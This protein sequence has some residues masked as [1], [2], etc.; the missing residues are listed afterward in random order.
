MSDSTRILYWVD[1]GLITFAIARSLQEKL[2]SESFAIYDLN[3]HLKNSFKDQKLVKFKKEWF[4][5]D[6]LSKNIEKVDLEYLKKIEKKYDINLWKLA[7][8]E[9][10]FSDFNEFY[11]FESDQILSILEQECKF[12]ER[13]LD[14]INPKFLIIKLTDFHRNHLLVEMASRKN[15]KILMLIPSKMGY[16]ANIASKINKFDE[17]PEQELSNKTIDSNYFKKYDRFKQTNQIKS[18]GIGFSKKQKV[19]SAIKWALKTAD[20]KYLETYDHYGV[21]VIKVIKSSFT[22]FFKIK[23]RKRYLDKKSSKEI[24]ENEKYILFP[25]HVEPERNID[26]DAIFFNDQLEVVKK[27]AK[28]LPVDYLLYVKEH[29]NMIFRGWRKINFYKDICELPNVKLIHPSVN[30][31]KLIENSSLVITISGT[32]GLEAVVQ[33][34]PAI[35]FADVIYDSIPSV[36]KVKEIEKLPELIRQ[37]LGEKVNM[38]EVGKF[39][40]IL[41]KNSFDFDVWAFHSKVIEKFHRGG[42]LIA[43]VI[44][45]EELE[46]FLNQNKE[47]INFL[48]DEYLK[49]IQK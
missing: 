28:S 12:F 23:L 3:H 20:K 7:Y 19:L 37:C 17:I 30:P 26:I 29:Y 32:M 38:E 34:K 6:H 22:G 13:I 27:I 2:K 24:I 44:A 5:W 1:A 15:I 4:F 41:D 46:Q 25:L 42:F 49:K 45:M 31:K 21:S 36:H 33:G 8:G 47:E 18:G 48:A 10:V 11:K 43:D 14:E 39:L 35:V 40:N 16:K 9:R